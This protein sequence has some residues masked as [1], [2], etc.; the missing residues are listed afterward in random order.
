LVIA[1]C[2][3]VSFGVVYLLRMLSLAYIT[4]TPE[5]DAMP[6]W[7]NTMLRT[8]AVVV[9][10]IVGA[11][12]SFTGLNIVLSICVGLCAGILNTTIVKVIKTRIKNIKL[13][14]SDEDETEDEAISDKQ[15][16]SGSSKE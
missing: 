15:E 7:W 9:G 16:P 11:L 14:S 2:A 1:V 13:Q 10:G 3:V 8:S 6:W 4:H 5:D 12:I